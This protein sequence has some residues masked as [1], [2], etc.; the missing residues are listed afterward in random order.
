MSRRP[1]ALV[2][3][4]ATIG[5]AVY[6]WL[7]RDT[8][9]WAGVPF[10]EHPPRS[11]R[12]PTGRKSVHDTERVYVADADGISAIDSLTGEVR[13]RQPGPHGELCLCGKL[14]VAIQHEDGCWL[15]ARSCVTGAEAFRIQ[16]PSGY[17]C[18]AVR[19][20]CGDIVVQ[21]SCSWD[22]NG[23]WVIDRDGHVSYRFDLYILDAHG[24]GN[25]RVFLTSRGIMRVG[26]TTWSIQVG[27]NATYS[28]GVGG[29]LRYLP[30]G[31]IIAFWYCGAS[32]TGVEVVR[33]NPE[34][35]STLWQTRCAGLGVTHS[36]YR[37]WAEVETRETTA[38]ITSRGDGGTFFEI[39]DLQTGRQLTRERCRS[40]LPW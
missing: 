23:A 17:Q 37:H 6:F 5:C 24:I 30:D 4:L 25:D 20:L 26:A 9:E 3:L 32:D 12:L 33:F 22:A 14:L 16:L 19:E 8:G 7:G 27:H 13:W 2:V 29:A 18:I 31:D 36:A 21:E 40:W 10:P 11:L 1:Y 35:G 28:P 39:L 38:R 34:T 15:L